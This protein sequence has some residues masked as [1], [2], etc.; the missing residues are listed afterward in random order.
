MSLD[1]VCFLVG[2][3]LVK[4]AGLPTSIELAGKLKED[5]ERRCLS[6]TIGESERQQ[7]KAA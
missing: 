3:G 7:A 1:R 6:T 5:L 4:D 2:A